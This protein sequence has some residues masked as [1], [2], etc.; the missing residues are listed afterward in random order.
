[1]LRQ[2]KIGPPQEAYTNGTDWR[3]IM[4]TEVKAD[5]YTLKEAAEVLKVGPQTVI[6]YIKKGLLVARKQGPRGLWRV[7]VGSVNDFMERDFPELF[8]P[9]AAL[10]GHQNRDQALLPIGNNTEQADKMTPVTLDDKLSAADSRIIELYNKG[11]KQSE[12][13][14][15]L[16]DENLVNIYRRVSWC[17]STV[18]IRIKSL[19]KRGLLQTT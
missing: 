16:I 13:A 8:M 17:Q 5:H 14:Q 15:T 6:R 1:M 12:I 3:I 7:S 18:S 10:G 2:V 9:H 11:V 19:R 4:S